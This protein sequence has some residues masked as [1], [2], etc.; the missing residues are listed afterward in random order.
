MKTLSVEENYQR[1]TIKNYSTYRNSI[2]YFILHTGI[3]MELA[4]TQHDLTTNF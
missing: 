4:N 2:Q 1:K 3:W